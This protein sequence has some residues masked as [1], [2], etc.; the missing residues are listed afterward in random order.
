MLVVAGPGRDATVAAVATLV[1]LSLLI[2]AFNAEIA[3]SNLAWALFN[4]AWA[5]E[6]PLSN[7]ILL[8]H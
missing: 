8:T 4:S 5:V 6:T 2:F 3:E 1:A 7:S